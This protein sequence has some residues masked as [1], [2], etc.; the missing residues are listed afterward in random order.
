MRFFNIPDYLIFLKKTFLI[1]LV[2]FL[3]PHSHTNNDMITNLQKDHYDVMA[4]LRKIWQT[5]SFE[6]SNNL[7]NKQKGK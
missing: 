1:Y 6:N 5:F 7:I 3:I 2:V 4:S